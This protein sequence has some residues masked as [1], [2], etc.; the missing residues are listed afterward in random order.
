MQEEEEYQIRVCRLWFGHFHAADEKGGG[1]LE[2]GPPKK[3]TWTDHSKKVTEDF[4]EGHEKIR[5]HRVGNFR[6]Q[7]ELDR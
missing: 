1:E 6:A 5:G 7:G 3:I 2:V 4:W